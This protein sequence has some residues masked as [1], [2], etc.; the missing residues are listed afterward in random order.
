MPTPEPPAEI[1]YD[2]HSKLRSGAV[3]RTKRQARTP[4][5]RFAG[6]TFALAAIVL[7]ASGPAGSLIGGAGINGVEQDLQQRADEKE[8]ARR[9]PPRPLPSPLKWLGPDRIAGRIRSL[10]IHPTNA[11]IVYAGSATGGVWKTTDGG[12][13]WSSLDDFMPTQVIGTLAMDPQNP[14]TIYAGSGEIFTRRAEGLWLRGE[15]RGQGIFVSRDAGAT[16]RALASTQTPTNDWWFVSRI[17]I[18]PSA[19]HH[20]FAAT[21]TGLWQSTDGGQSFQRMLSGIFLDVRIHP[22]QP[23]N[24]VASALGGFTFFST[25]FGSNWT[26]SSP[27]AG[28]D[29]TGKRVELAAVRTI[30][31][32]RALILGPGGTAD[33]IVLL[34]SDD[35]G[36]RFD[37]AATGGVPI[38]CD[39]RG[40]NRVYTGALWVD[41]RDSTQMLVG[42]VRLC[43]VT[44][45]GGVQTITRVAVPSASDFHAIVEHPGFASGDDDGILVGFDQGVKRV[46]GID[47]AQPTFESLN[48]GL[49]TTQFHSAATN[50]ISNDVIGTTQD[51]SVLLREGDTWRQPIGAIED[52]AM[53]TTEL[54]GPDFLYFGLSIGRIFRSVDGG[55]TAECISAQSNAPITESFRDNDCG[56]APLAT[57]CGNKTPMLLD[58]NNANRLYVGCGQLWRTT[59]A[60]A[61]SASSINWA[62]VKARTGSFL[63]NAMDMPPGNPNLM[64]VGTFL[65]APDGDVLRDGQLWKTTNATANAPAWFRM[66]TGLPAR[67]VFDVVVDRNDH[68]TVYVSY[69]GFA[70]DNVWKT[71]NG[72]ASWTN[73]AGGLPAVPVWALAVHPT[74]PGWLYAG[75][76]VGL[77]TS[78]DDGAT[79]SATSRGPST[80]A[81]SD[82]QWKGNTTFLTVATYGRG[83]HELDARPNP[84]RLFPERLTREAGLFSSGH[85]ENLIV[86]DNKRFVIT[87]P[88]AGG[89]T[90]SVVLTTRGGFTRDTTPFGSDLQFF[91]E[92]LPSTN[93]EQRLEFFDFSANR[94]VT[95]Q[96]VPLTA[97][98]E[99]TTTRFFADGAARFISPA[100]RELQAR[101]TWTRATAGSWSV[102]IDAASW[103]ITRP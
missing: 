52:G 73:I 100:T 22:L 21:S 17:A 49:R 5:G 37:F 32:W 67:P 98:Q 79:W 87:T 10:V 6:W 24:V 68:E 9:L 8:K 41:P 16:W 3:S 83:T 11:N 29:V 57:F 93:V 84:E 74:E 31:H 19:S 102:R 80:V 77:Y 2:V 18:D 96:I 53:A 50:P 56:N 66:D 28:L 1:Q 97:G 94:F 86:S 15:D 69:S 13:T 75:T 20:M 60:R 63:I 43:K 48:N 90:L 81:I 25:N 34:R 95:M 91:I 78:T 27:P 101:L 26:V 46:R 55:T 59:D 7:V 71:S 92:A 58:P 72:G 47:D 44:V 42:G 70:A 61:A 38:L 64:W 30:G 45:V 51:T 35:S 62:S 89:D 88:R 85:V 14:N 99:R 65:R 40:N 23:R 12:L 33:N 4:G 103:R 54:N 82:L 76:D 39:G 36:A